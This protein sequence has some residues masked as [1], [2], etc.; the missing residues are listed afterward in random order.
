MKE[1][2]SLSPTGIVG[3]GFPEESFLAGVALKPDLIA[4]DGGSTDPGP[5]SLGSGKP[6]TTASA[7][8]RDLRLMVKAACDLGIPLVI[9]T[10]GGSGGTP[11]LERERKILLE[12][13]AE[14]KLSFKLAT[15]SSQLDQNF[16]V[17]QLHQGKILPL[18]PAP[19]PTE[20]DLLGCSRVVAQMGIEPI[21]QALDASRHVVVVFSDLAYLKSDWVSLEMEVFQGEMD[22]GRKPG[23]NFLMIVTKSVYDQI[24]Q[25]NKTLLPIEYRRCE[26]MC[27]EDYRER[28]LNYLNR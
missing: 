28:L 14:E 22:E 26:I 5:Y 21:M 12:I 6:F 8:K 2:K 24:M 13:A 18:G 23:A 1:F 10:A 17:Q 3:Y 9:G 11:H 16:L 15:V 7:V 27:M 25:S 20:E 19:M 4:C